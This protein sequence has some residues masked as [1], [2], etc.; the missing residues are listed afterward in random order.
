MNENELRELDGFIAMQVMGWKHARMTDSMGHFWAW[1]FTDREGWISVNEYYPTLKIFQAIEA[2]S[3]WA[4]DRP[5]AW[6]EIKASNELGGHVAV[7][8]IWRKAQAVTSHAIA[9]ALCLALKATVE[10]EQ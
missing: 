7:N 8:G 1:E 10:A 5:G 4:K 2:V 6:W 9:T 3:A